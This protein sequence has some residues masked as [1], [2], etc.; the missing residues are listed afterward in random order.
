MLDAIPPVFREGIAGL[1]VER[2][3]VSHPT[4]PGVYTLGECVTQDWPDPLGGQGELQSHIV[5]YHGSF[6]GLAGDDP[7]F[8]WEAE[9]WE[10]MLHELLHH[11]EAA[12]VEDALDRF[13]WA[14][15]QNY[16]R[17]AG[18]PFD[19]TFPRVLPADEDGAMRLEGE[20][21]VESVV[22]PADI[23]AR[24][25]WRERSYT[26]RVPSTEEPVWIRIRNLAGGRLWVIVRRRLSWWRRLL[27]AGAGGPTP[28][29]ERRALPR[30]PA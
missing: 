2:E 17:L 27:A 6:E 1:V 16:L 4:L 24:F 20:T 5:L 8:D 26:L 9:L 12:A 13:D 21:F 7:Q 23:E 10:T 22:G 11:R 19:P 14:V 28:I 3:T 25:R 29:L 15:D 30:G 18:R